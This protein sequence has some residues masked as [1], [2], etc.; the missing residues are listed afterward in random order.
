MQI[1]A[2]EVPHVDL[3]HVD[4]GFHKVA[5]HQQGPAERIVAVAFEDF[6]TGLPHIEGRPDFRIADQ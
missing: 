2:A 4:A 5:G 6:R 1:P 3:H